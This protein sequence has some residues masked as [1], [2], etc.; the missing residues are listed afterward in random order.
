MPWIDQH[1]LVVAAAQRY[2]LPPSPL[3]AEARL[4]IYEAGLARAAVLANID[5]GQ[6]TDIAP[7]I[8]EVLP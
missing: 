3:T 7:P 6:L 2:G 8:D 4:A 1:E 5:P